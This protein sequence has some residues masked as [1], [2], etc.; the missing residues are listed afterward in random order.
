LT[1]TRSR[2]T[3]TQLPKVKGGKETMK[4]KVAMV[5]LV[6]SSLA[7]IVFGQV[8]QTTSD[9]KAVFEVASIK[10][11][12]SPIVST[13]LAV[14]P[15]GR[16]RVVGAPVFW[17]IAG[18][19]GDATGGL[20]P[21]QVVNAP[22]WLSSE[23]YDINAKAADAD[24]LGEGA[25]FIRVRPYLQSLLEDRFQ[26]K[27]HRE[28]RDLPIYALVR[29]GK[30]GALGPGL[31]RSTVDCLKDAA[32]CG[33]RGGPVGRIKAEALTSDLLMQ[34]LGNAVGRVVVDHMGLEGPFAVDLEWSPDQSTSDKPSIFTAVQEQLGLKLESTRG[35]VDVL[36]IDHV[37][38]PTPN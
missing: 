3:I 13:T 23:R 29:S 36:V 11:N 38:P 1:P 15:G 34:L 20:R 8:R 32:K 18:A 35:P 10:Q 22:G 21:E 31:S 26:L 24:A 33:V 14:D 2:E 19:Y 16:V 30:N 27:T 9:Q 17:L 25:T 5:G 7:A 37:E 12:T 28:R 4:Y 6:A